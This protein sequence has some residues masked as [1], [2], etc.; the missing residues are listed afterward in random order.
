MAIVTKIVEA[1]NPLVID[2]DSSIGDRCPS[3]VQQGGRRHQDDDAGILV[4]KPEDRG[5][6]QVQRRVDREIAI[7]SAAGCDPSAHG[8]RCPYW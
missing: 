4:R 2:M 6:G 7:P 8:G 1:M 5:Y 3:A